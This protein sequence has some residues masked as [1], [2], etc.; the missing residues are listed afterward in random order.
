M[1]TSRAVLRWL[2]A[3]VLVGLLAGGGYLA[4]RELRGGSEEARAE[5]PAASETEAMLAEGTPTP[6]GTVRAEE[7]C[8]GMPA[9]E[10]VSCLA[11]RYQ[12]MEAEDWAK[13]PFRGQIGHFLVVPEGGRAADRKPVC[14]DARVEFALREEQARR[15]ELAFPFPS[16]DPGEVLMGTVCGEGKVVG[17]SVPVDVPSRGSYLAR[18]FYVDELLPIPVRAPR[19]R[20]LLTEIAGYEALVELPVIREPAELSRGRIRVIE[21]LPEPGRPGIF[22][23]MVYYGPVE[24]AIRFLEEMIRKATGGGE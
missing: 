12:A 19:E 24:E 11:G 3:G 13:E 23:G 16:P 22:W 17:F 9:A 6:V 10:Q 21:R 2:A 4:G 14:E 18:Y 7:E 15:S 1:L 8:L 20:L 5:L